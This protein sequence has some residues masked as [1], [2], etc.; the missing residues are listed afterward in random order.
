[1]VLLYE[2][3]KTREQKSIAMLQDTAMDIV[4]RAIKNY[5]LHGG[6]AIWRCYNGNRFSY[7]L[8]FY[9]DSRDICMRLEKQASVYG[10]RMECSD[11]KKVYARLY[12]YNSHVGIQAERKK[13]RGITA[14]FLK[15][16]GSS[17]TVMVLSPTAIFLEKISA[18]TDRLE[19]KDLYDLYLLA[20]GS[21]GGAYSVD[22]TKVKGKLNGM[23]AGFKKPSDSWG[24]LE[25]MILH[26]RL[27]PISDTLDYLRK[28][29]V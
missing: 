15:G 7:D 24:S 1:M 11:K 13:V 21:E 3:L 19:S 29:S 5:V 2:E 10:L 17:L 16:N 25:A 18:Y 20:S 12:G 8:D 14:N 23:I 22:K 9:F 26:G 6:T 28:W 4:D 27:P